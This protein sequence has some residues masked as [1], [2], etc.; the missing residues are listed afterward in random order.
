M[1]MTQMKMEQ[2]LKHDEA[3]E[4]QRAKTLHRSLD[5]GSIIINHPLW[6]A[7]GETVKKSR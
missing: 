3:E 2:I 5:V 7:A 4:T 1:D 6:G